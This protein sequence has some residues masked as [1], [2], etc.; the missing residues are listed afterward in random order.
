MVPIICLKSRYRV[1][2]DVNDELLQFDDSRPEI[3]S[4]PP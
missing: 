4:G 2:N 3:L 1:E